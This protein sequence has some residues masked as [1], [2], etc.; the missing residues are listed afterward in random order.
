MNHKITEALIT[1]Q[2]EQKAFKSGA[3]TIKR[4]PDPQLDTP[5]VVTLDQLHA[6]ENNPRQT[7]NPL[8]DGLKASIKAR[9]LD[10]PPPITRRP[11]EDQFII[12]TGGNTRLA[13]LNELY[14]ETREDR[15]FRIHC[16][17]RPWQSEANALIGHLAENELHGALTFI[18]RAQG[19]AQMKALYEA[20]LSEQ[21]SL[22]K[23]SE[24][25]RADGYPMSHVLI[26]RMLECI[27]SIQPALPNTLLS[28]LG[29]DQVNRLITF[30]NSLTK[31]WNKYD[32]SDFLDFWLMVLSTHDNDPQSFNFE[33]I[34]DQMLGQMAAMLEQD[35]HS[36]ELDLEIAGNKNHLDKNPLSPGA[37]KTIE[38]NPP[39]SIA[40]PAPSSETN[41]H[42]D[43]NTEE[44]SEKKEDWLD[45]DT[46][47]AHKEPIS[48]INQ[49]ER[50]SPSNTIKRSDSEHQAIIDG[51]IV[52]LSNETERVTRIKQQVEQVLGNTLPNFEE[53]ALKAI[54][55]MAGGRMANVSDVWYIE[56]QIDSPAELRH[57]ISL[58]VG[59]LAHFANI[60]G[61]FATQEGLGFGFDKL[62]RDS[63]PTSN[64]VFLLLTSLLRLNDNHSNEQLPAPLCAAL[65]SQILVGSYDITIGHNSAKDIGLTRLP[66]V[67]LVKLFR[68][69]RLARRL[70]DYCKEEDL[71]HAE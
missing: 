26:S 3:S 39:Q 17:F 42:S 32:D 4:L 13:I 51:H 37:L 24:R 65:F 56:K 60:K 5:M 1:E 57:Q 16:L 70:V 11:G 34:R 7:R 68:L 2:L 35:Y 67:E 23:L 69:I 59:D 33:V 52:S 50:Q 61:V 28:G 49:V 29:G 44:Y 43:P 31:V 63:N 53:N 41:K 36:L 54:P 18:E 12:S 20:E 45:N 38:A 22:R 15:F 9:G 19:V 21:L 6:Y 55:V 10:H 40:S 66:D 25:L 71:G 48:Q 46:S 27:N 47:D 62:E 30:K 14:A 8:Y 64:T 58:L